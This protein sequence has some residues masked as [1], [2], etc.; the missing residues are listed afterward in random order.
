MPVSSIDRTIIES[1]EGSF[2]DECKISELINKG[3]VISS[4]PEFTTDLND[5]AIELEKYWIA[6]IN[7]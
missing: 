6:Y 5:N 4:L 2:I 1:I 7:A 3:G